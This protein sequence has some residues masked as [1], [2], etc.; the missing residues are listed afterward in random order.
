M[1]RRKIAMLLLGVALVGL[2]A[3]TDCFVDADT[4]VVVDDKVLDFVGN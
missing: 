2:N 4:D 3:G 1:W